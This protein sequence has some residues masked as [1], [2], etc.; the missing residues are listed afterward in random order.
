M[1]LEHED[2][3]ASDLRNIIYVNYKCF[4]ASIS[5]NQRLERTSSNGELAIVDFLRLEELQ[6]INYSDMS[7]LV[8]SN[9]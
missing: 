9:H 8:D 3:N 2:V 1:K 6:E 7:L 5:R 4:D